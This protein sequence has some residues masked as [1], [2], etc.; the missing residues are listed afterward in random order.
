MTTSDHTTYIRRCACVS[1][2]SAALLL[3]GSVLEAAAQSTA[4]A[5]GSTISATPFS[6]RHVERTL[7]PTERQ[8]RNPFRQIWTPVEARSR[9]PLR[10]IWSPV[11]AAPL[12][13]RWP[14]R[15]DPRRWPRLFANTTECTVSFDPVLRRHWWQ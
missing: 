15:A 4:A 6:L 7:A 10:L 2:I 9:K 11:D 5:V 3:G 14:L 8:P 1:V 13:G 12:G